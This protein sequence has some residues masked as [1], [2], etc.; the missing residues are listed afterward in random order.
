MMRAVLAV[1]VGYVWWTAVW[2]AGNS[3]FFG[4]AADVVGA[5]EPY[6]E[7]G[8]LVGA[9]GLS[10]ACSLMAGMVAG[11]L[12]KS[13]RLVS[14]LAIV[15]LVTGIGVQASVWSLMPLWYHLVFLALLV[16][17]TRLGG[18]LTAAKRAA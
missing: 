8:P 7:A 3:V 9:L 4:E 13:Q 18:K 14:I 12:G 2:L 6:T 11:M 10:M 16:P 1:V 17:A 5:G 15:L